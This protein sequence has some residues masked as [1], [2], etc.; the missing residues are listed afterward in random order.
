MNEQQPKRILDIPQPVLDARR[1]LA[2]NFLEEVI[3]GV[4]DGEISSAD[5]LKN[6]HSIFVEGHRGVGDDFDLALSWRYAKVRHTLNQTLAESRSDD[7][8]DEDAAHVE[9]TYQLLDEVVF[10]SSEA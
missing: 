8:I 4:R 5:D 2:Q 6:Q 7:Y 10:S 3:V 9:R 1:E